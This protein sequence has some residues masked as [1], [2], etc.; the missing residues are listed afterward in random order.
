MSNGID[1]YGSALPPTAFGG[2]IPAAFSGHGLGVGSNA[3]DTLSRGTSH[4]SLLDHLGAAQVGPHDLL[5]P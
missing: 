2:T 5:H 3:S 4:A 1:L